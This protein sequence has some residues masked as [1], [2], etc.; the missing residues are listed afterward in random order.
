MA[1]R[2]V[3]ERSRDRQRH[4]TEIA[5]R[6]WSEQGFEETTVSELCAAAGV[7]KGSFYFYFRSKEALLLEVGLDLTDNMFDGSFD[8]SLIGQGVDAMLDR[9]VVLLARRLSAIPRDLVARYLAEAHHHVSDWEE[10]RGDRRDVVSVLSPI[11]GRAIRRGEIVPGYGPVELGHVLGVSL[12]DAIMV[13]AQEKDGGLGLEEL[14][15]RRVRLLLG[16]VAAR[17][18]VSSSGS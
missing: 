2:R 13:W 12:N 9:V 8:D 7:S 6:L 17:D 14:L 10:V 4:L 16:G 18:L 11:F 15:R 5:M 3:Q 1:T